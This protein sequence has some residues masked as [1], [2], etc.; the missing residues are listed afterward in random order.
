MHTD[1]FSMPYY[2]ISSK[3]ENTSNELVFA[4]FYVILLVSDTLDLNMK[5]FENLEKRPY[6]AGMHA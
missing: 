2:D 1:E 3:F 4:D 6:H 5:S